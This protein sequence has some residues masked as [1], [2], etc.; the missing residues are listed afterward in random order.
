LEPTIGHLKVEH[1]LEPNR[2]RSTTGDAINAML[3]ATEMNL[4][5]QQSF[6]LAQWFGLLGKL[7]PGKHK[8]QP[9]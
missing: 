6:F 3:K 4:G 1:R 5:K 8:I 7:S 9:T 2:M